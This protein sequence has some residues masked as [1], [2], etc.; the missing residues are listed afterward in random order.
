MWESLGLEPVESMAQESGQILINKARHWGPLLLCIHLN[1]EHAYYYKKSGGG[2]KE[3]Y[4]FAW[5]VMR[6]PFT[7]INTAVASVGDG[8][9]EED[10]RG[11]TMLQYDTEGRPLFLHRNLRKYTTGYKPGLKNDK[12]DNSERSWH[13]VKEC[14]PQR[15]G[16]TNFEC[17]ALSSFQ[18]GYMMWKNK[19]AS[20]QTSSC[21]FQSLIGFDIEREVLRG[22]KHL[23]DAPNYS[24]YI[25]DLVVA[26][27]PPG[28]F[29][30]KSP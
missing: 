3:T 24:H 26:Q 11:Y 9:G 23:F 1:M 16:I 18:G 12:L 4:H 27:G 13:V 14:Q 29:I 7:M 19:I 10:F 30:S 28:P 6:A 2:D 22:F 5:R 17:S 8:L 15:K 20:V 25:H 21:P